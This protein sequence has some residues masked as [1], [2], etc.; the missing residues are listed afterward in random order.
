MTQER[1][2]LPTAPTATLR[3]TLHGDRGTEAALE[4]ADKAAR[5]LQD[6]L[7]HVA[8]DLR[9]DSARGIQTLLCVDFDVIRS[10]L[11]W[12]AEESHESLWSSLCI[13]FSRKNLVFLPG[14]LFETLSFVK[15]HHKI[16]RNISLS[17]FRDLFY[18]DVSRFY[19]NATVPEIEYRSTLQSFERISVA[20]KTLYMLKSLQGRL[21]KAQQHQLPPVD[22]D[23]F[24]WASE[25]LSVGMRSDRWI[26]NRVDAINYSLVHKLNQEINKT[27]T[28]YVTCL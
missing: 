3:A 10:S 7:E 25:T 11:E 17:P 28:R 21:L 9:V 18:D 24:D 13:N 2:R 6:D 26:N 23:V 16:A 14:S 22:R 8:E 27:R 15:S 5:D 1:P 20:P 19:D 12:F 4:A